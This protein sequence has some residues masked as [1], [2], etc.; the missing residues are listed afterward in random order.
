MLPDEEITELGERETVTMPDGS[1]LCLR[2]LDQDYDPYD[3]IRA[4]SYVQEAQ[5][6]GEVVTGL[7]YVDPDAADCHEVLD[8]VE[9]PLNALGETEL[10]PGNDALQ[11]INE[12]LR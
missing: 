8:T 10:C 12:S 5:R 1:Q 7:L 9:T 3:R 6:D 11:K 2:K 4:L